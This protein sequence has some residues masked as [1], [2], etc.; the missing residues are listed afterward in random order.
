MVF[1]IMQHTCFPQFHSKCTRD[2]VPEQLAGMVL[3][4][5]LSVWFPIAHFDHKT[6]AIG[7]MA[8]E[9]VICEIK[10]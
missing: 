5:F 10:N 2:T 4:D 1:G 9:F 7:R 6:T 3:P 8:T